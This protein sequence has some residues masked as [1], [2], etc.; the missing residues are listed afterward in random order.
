MLVQRS[1]PLLS[2]WQLIAAPRR[3]WEEAFWYGQGLP[4]RAV[5]VEVELDVE[6]YPEPPPKPGGAVGTGS[7]GAVHDLCV[8]VRVGSVV[9][10]ASCWD[11]R[12]VAVGEV[13]SGGGGVVG[14][15]G[16][17]VGTV[18]SGAGVAGNGASARATEGEPG[19]TAK[20]SASPPRA[21]VLAASAS[22]LIRGPLSCR[23]RWRLRVRSG[24]EGCNALLLFHSYVTLTSP[25]V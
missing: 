9:A 7:I 22:R 15:D 19:C 13:V 3:S 25:T 5:D 24:E 17:E 2:G 1:W 8:R 21:S 23:R 6:P 11:V 14:A 12:D 16:G 20:P 18:S 4:S 10:T